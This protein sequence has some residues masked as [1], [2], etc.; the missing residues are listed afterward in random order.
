MISGLFS[1]KY[2]LWIS[3]VDCYLTRNTKRCW[4]FSTRGLCTVAQDELIFIFDDNLN[5]A[6][7]LIS[8]ILNHIHQI[9]ED[10]TRGSFVRHLGLS[11][12]S[13]SSTFLTSSTTAGFLYFADSSVSY[14]LFPDA[15]YLFGILI[16]RLELPT[17]QCFPLR[18][19]LR[20][21]YEYQSRKINILL[22]F[23]IQVFLRLSMAII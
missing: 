19:L 23:V 1:I 5:N 4:I 20:L 3:L 21:G 8:D 13:K 7:E 2:L 11:L 18:L 22:L 10:A 17:A 14:S 12:S 6:N 16:D 15:P 9:Y